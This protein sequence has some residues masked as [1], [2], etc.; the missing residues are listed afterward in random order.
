MLGGFRA[1]VLSSVVLQELYAGAESKGLKAVGKLEDEL[2][3]RG[4]NPGS[5]PEQLGKAEPPRL[6]HLHGSCVRNYQGL[7]P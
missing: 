7:K 6:R 1:G 5:E 4:A 2:Q 3:E